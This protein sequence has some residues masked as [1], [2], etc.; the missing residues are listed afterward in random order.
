MENGDLLTY[1]RTH[2]TTLKQKVTFFAD[3]AAGMEY[4]AH[5]KFYHRDL[6][7]RNIL[8]GKNPTVEK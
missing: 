5:R 3:I 7:A 2:P 6:A 4:L 1:V 8:L